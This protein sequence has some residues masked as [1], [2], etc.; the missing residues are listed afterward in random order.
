MNSDLQRFSAEA[1]AQRRYLFRCSSQVSVRR[2]RNLDRGRELYD[3][4]Q[5]YGK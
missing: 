4:K 3:C 2:T 1:S 5:D